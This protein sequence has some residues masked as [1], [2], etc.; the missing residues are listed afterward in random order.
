MEFDATGNYIRGWGVAKVRGYEWPKDEHGIFVDYKNNVWLSS[1]GWSALR[2][3]TENMILS[4]RDG[5]FI[6][7]VGKRG[8]Q[9]ASA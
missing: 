3:R 1:S 4:S 9:G 7:Q 2:E 5:K 8:Q 6:F